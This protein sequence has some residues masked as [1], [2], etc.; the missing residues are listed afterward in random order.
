[1]N[2]K[3]NWGI[4][5]L[6][7]I[8]EVFANDLQLCEQAKLFGVASRDLKK[9]EKFAKRFNSKTYFGSYEKL[10]QNPE[11]DVVYIATPHVF[12]FENTMC[13]LQNNKSVLC[14]KPLGMNLRQVKKM[15][16]K[17]EKEKLFLMEGLWSR[18]IPA[19]EKLLELLKSG[20][21]GEIVS[22]RADFGF[23][24][25]FDLSSRI[26]NKALGG[27]SLLDV[28]IYPIYLSLL[29]LGEP[30]AIEAMARFA[31]TGVDSYCCILFDYEK[32]EKAV[33]ESSIESD[34]PLTAYIYGTEGRIKLHNRFHHCQK[35]SL[36]KHDGK[37][38]VY[39]IAYKGNGY[40]HEIQQVNKSLLEGQIQNKKHSRQMSEA[41]MRTLDRVRRKIGLIYN[42][43]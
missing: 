34:T 39:E 42:N 30:K 25:P 19:T 16:E 43:V 15:F 18:F 10:M 13:C 37:K 6:G 9:A 35:I 26:Y 29:L 41:L 8:A 7:S 32:K 17:A 38:K 33:L 4:I 40:L 20:E 21:I 11:I 3:I 36:F 24:P 22:I 31:S 28:G 27:G 14:E 12:H 23:R 5:G 1:M 2:K